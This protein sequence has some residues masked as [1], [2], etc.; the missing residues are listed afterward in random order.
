[1]IADDQILQLADDALIL[2]HRCAQWLT[3]A[4]EIEEDVA[5]ANIGLDLLGQS[6]L[7]YGLVGDEDELAYFRPAPDWRHCL[8]VE[9]P[10]GDF[11]FTMARLLVFAHY[12]LVLADSTLATDERLSPIFA[13]SVKES[14]YHADHAT[15]WV[16]RL[17]DGTE[18]SHR[19][20]QSGLDSVWPYLDELF[21]PVRDAQPAAMAKIAR[22]IENATL[23][24]P[25]A[26]GR[27]VGGRHGRHTGHLSELLTDMQSVAREHAGAK[28]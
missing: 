13:K 18:V 27:H 6:R 14:R 16:L 2:S 10:N 4:P 7:L 24:V 3:R 23:S 5:L 12:Q 21:A 9:Q 1:M 20:M 28:W 19:R 25:T 26:V 15:Q 22:V 11:A 17:G 8:L